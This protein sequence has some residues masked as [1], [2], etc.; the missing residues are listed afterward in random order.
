M[1]VSNLENI[2]H[3]PQGHV[4]VL[5]SGRGS[6]FLSILDYSRRDD[7][8]FSVNLV[9]SDNEMAP[10]LE[11]AR[12]EGLLALAVKPSDFA[13]RAAYEAEICRRLESQ[14]TDLVCLAGYMR[15]VG[16]TLLARYPGRIMN[17]HPALLPAFPGLHAQKQALDWGVRVSGCTVHFVDAGMDTGP[18]ILQ[19]TV[20]VYDGDDE[21]MLS[22]RILAEEH[23]LYP[24]AITLFFN[25]CLTRQGRKVTIRA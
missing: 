15:L 10:G 17:V 4:A 20:P 1:T 14:R 18:I 21:E 16:K 9:I 6:N 24:Q 13:D 12:Q 23:R 3:K 8:P 22:S 7:S 5:L 25:G 2:S 11:R 19:Q